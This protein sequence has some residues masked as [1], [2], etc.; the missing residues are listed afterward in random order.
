MSS[1]WK[2]TIPSTL[3]QG[4]DDRNSFE[5]IFPDLPDP[6]DLNEIKLTPG[7]AYLLECILPTNNR[8]RQKNK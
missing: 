8:T 7:S 4:Y 1:D 6:C 5:A 2:K 3:I